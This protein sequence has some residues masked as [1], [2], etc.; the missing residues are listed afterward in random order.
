MELLSS[1]LKRRQGAGWDE[2]RVCD[3]GDPVRNLR[4]LEEAAQREVERGTEIAVDPEFLG[5]IGAAETGVF[6][7]K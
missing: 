4:V 6:G 5:P 3:E 2:K 7:I 1:V